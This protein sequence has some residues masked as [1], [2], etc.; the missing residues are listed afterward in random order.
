MVRLGS[1]QVAVVAS[2]NFRLLRASRAILPMALLPTT[3]SPPTLIQP[4]GLPAKAPPADPNAT[5]RATRALANSGV[6]VVTNG[7]SVF[8]PVA[9]EFNMGANEYRSAAYRWMVAYLQDF[10]AL[11]FWAELRCQCF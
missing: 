9:R 4:Y 10:S 1:H 5:A 3:H 7:V 2:T 6:S 11:F 8:S